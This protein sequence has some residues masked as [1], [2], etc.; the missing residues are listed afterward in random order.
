MCAYVCVCQCDFYLNSPASHFQLLVQRLKRDRTQVS[1]KLE[2]ASFSHHNYTLDGADVTL[3]KQNNGFQGESALFQC[4]SDLINA[5]A[6]GLESTCPNHKSVR[7]VSQVSRPL[8]GKTPS[9]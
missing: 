4:F 3:V 6:V 5:A 2:D 1:H 8:Q 9:G 7:H